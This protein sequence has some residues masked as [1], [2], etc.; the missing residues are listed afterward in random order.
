[1]ENLEGLYST[2]TTKHLDL[3]GKYNK[4]EK[5]YNE[6]KDECQQM[7]S[8]VASLEKMMKTMLDKDKKQPP[9]D[10]EQYRGRK[11]DYGIGEA[12]LK[13]NPD[14][15][16][17]NK[18]SALSDQMSTGTSKD[19][20]IGKNYQNQQYQFPK[21]NQSIIVMNQNR[22]MPKF[23]LAGTKKWD[24]FV[25]DFE[26]TCETKLGNDTQLWMQE[27][28][29]TLEG[30]MK[31]QFNNMGGMDI[32]Y[33]TMKKKLGEFAN[34]RRPDG[35]MEKANFTA[36][37]MERSDTVSGYAERL[38]TVFRREYPDVDHTSAYP[39]I[40][41]LIETAPPD[42]ASRIRQNAHNMKNF[43]QAEPN[44]DNV[45]DWIAQLE[46]EQGLSSQKPMSYSDIIKGSGPVPNPGFSQ[47]NVNYVGTYG[48]LGIGNKVQCRACNGTGWYEKTGMGRY[49][50]SYNIKRENTGYQSRGNAKCTYCHRV[51]HDFSVCRR[52]L[53]QCLRCGARDHFVYQCGQ[54]NQGY[55]NN[56][57][58]R[59]CYVC[60][61]PGHI[62]KDCPQRSNN[63]KAGAAQTL[64]S[65]AGK[66]SSP[67]NV[68]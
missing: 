46:N 48:Q 52:R 14:I 67:G 31:A 3:S 43:A 55:S 18:F 29:E 6:I 19:Q 68:K 28:F 8:Q 23:N 16:T 66:P 64:N 54:R 32:D 61:A 39:L 4:L 59:E 41:K 2:L 27:L 50:H 49:G 25:E 9:A 58:G 33:R 65:G 57:K 45:K 1:M 40:R 60:S 21:P 11:D 36:M 56:N 20:G 30:E 10:E 62:A 17:N 51:G 15:K 53:G 26:R 7:K 35:L 37:I 5:E 24:R 63:S 38:E 47:G 44:W 34:R 12:L 42:F 13:N 22:K